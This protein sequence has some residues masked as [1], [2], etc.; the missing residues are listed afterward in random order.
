VNAWW[1]WLIACFGSHS[2]SMTYWLVHFWHPVGGMPCI[3]LRQ[4]VEWRLASCSGDTDLLVYYGVPGIV[5]WQLD[6]WR[7]A[8]WSGDL[9]ILMIVMSGSI[10][11]VFWS[12]RC[13]NIV[14]R[15]DEALTSFKCSTSYC[16]RPMIGVQHH[17]LD[18]WWLALGII[19]DALDAMVRG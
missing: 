8:L 1:T 15:N 14:I 11:F 2:K 5:L 6:N 13:V 16:G 3:V 12:M 7:P 18:T 9:V 10:D 4:P 17:A 19:C